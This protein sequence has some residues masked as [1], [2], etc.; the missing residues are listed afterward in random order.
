MARLLPT[1][2]RAEAEAYSGALADV[3]CWFQGFVAAD[4]DAPV[5]RSLDTLRELNITMKAVVRESDERATRHLDR[6][7]SE[8]CRENPD[9]ERI[10]AAADCAK[11]E[12]FPD[13]SRAPRAVPF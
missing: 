13:E 2:T 9:H 3:L 5:P 7:V 4:R 11:A 12:L 10:Q 8:A 1:I 6:M